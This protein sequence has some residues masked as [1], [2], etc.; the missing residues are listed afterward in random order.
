MLCDINFTLYY[1]LFLPAKQR[2]QRGSPGAHCPLIGPYHPKGHFLQKELPLASAFLHHPVIKV[3]YKAVCWSSL[4]CKKA[5]LTPTNF[6]FLWIHVF[7]VTSLLYL[8]YFNYFNREDIANFGLH[9]QG[10]TVGNLIKFNRGLNNRRM[11]FSFRRV[12]KLF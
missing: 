11:T 1:A 6:L 12:F 2:Q 5:S 4:I 9:K 8:F 10:D 3:E 7:F